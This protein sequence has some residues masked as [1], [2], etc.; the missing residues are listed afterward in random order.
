MANS[1]F[2]VP[3]HPSEGVKP[4]RLIP[5]ASF[6]TDATEETTH[7]FYVAEDG[8]VATG[9]W[10]CDPHRIEIDSY[11]INEQMTI[12]AGKLILTNQAGVVETF[13]PG[14]VVFVSRGSK[15]TWEVTERLRKY[16]MTAA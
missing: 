5:K 12:M 10:E 11:P 16:F 15:L 13:G 6:T 1:T 7:R 9:V 8:S 14:E 4:S 3:A 2:K